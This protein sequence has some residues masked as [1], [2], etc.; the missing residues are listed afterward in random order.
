M[1]TITQVEAEITRLEAELTSEGWG[2]WI[3]R[4]YDSL[5]T[6][7][8][9]SIYYRLGELNALKWALQRQTRTVRGK[10]NWM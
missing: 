6:S 2:K 10:L 1:L 9:K 8:D 4:A 7:G 5:F 3:V